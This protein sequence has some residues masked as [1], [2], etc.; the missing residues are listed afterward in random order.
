MELS[1]PAT[2]PPVDIFPIL[3]YVPEQFAKWK[4]E[5]RDAKTDHW[6]I[7]RGF[8]KPVQDRLARG[9]GNGCFMETVYQRSEEWGIEGDTMVSVLYFYL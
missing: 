7:Y 2:Q 5:W 4:K 9:E 1:N 6:K 3:K 8:L